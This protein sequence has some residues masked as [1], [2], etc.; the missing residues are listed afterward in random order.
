M[1]NNRVAADG[2]KIWVVMRKLLAAAEHDRY[3]AQSIG[4]GGSCKS[5]VEQLKLS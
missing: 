3:A 1:S 4:E 2:I 5:S